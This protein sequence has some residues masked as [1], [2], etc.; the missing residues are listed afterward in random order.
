MSTSTFN[1]CATLSIELTSHVTFLS[2]SIAL[3]CRRLLVNLW[4]RAS[5]GVPQFSKYSICIT[6][7]SSLSE[8]GGRYPPMFTVS[9]SRLQRS[10][11]SPLRVSSPESILFL[12][13]SSTAS[14]TSMLSLLVKN[15]VA[16]T[17]SNNLSSFVSSKCSDRSPLLFVCARFLLTL[18]RCSFFV[19]SNSCMY[20]S[21]Y[22][23]CHSASPLR[24]SLVIAN[25]A[26]ILLIS[27]EEL[28]ASS[29]PSPRVT[30][31]TGIFRL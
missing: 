14:C 19:S 16:S 31:T 5:F 27:N 4:I 2:N 20:S 6:S 22:F 30:I 24:H 10:S 3:S 26:L 1:R 9:Y 25:L 28:L 11:P 13:R 8:E 21:L 29:L 23:L 15:S 18:A 12:C 7:T 17:P